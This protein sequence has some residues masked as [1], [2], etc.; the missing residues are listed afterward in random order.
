M[1]TLRQI[2]QSIEYLQEQGFSIDKSIHGYCWS[3]N[4]T[5]E[6]GD[7]IYTTQKEAIDACIDDNDLDTYYQID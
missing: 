6:E 1:A 2:K 5:G 4:A 3:N 7:T